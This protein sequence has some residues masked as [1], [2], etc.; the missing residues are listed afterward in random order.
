MILFPMSC[1]VL[2]PGHIKC[3]EY[4]SRI[5]QVVVSLLTAKAMKGYKEEFTPYK[6]REKIL[7]SLYLDLIVVPQNSLNP[8]SNLKKY[9]CDSIASGDGWE[10]EELEAIEKLG[11]RKI[12]IKL[13]KKYSSTNIINNIKKY[14]SFRNTGR[15]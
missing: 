12:N 9:K 7:K 8:L 1:R 6:D 15:H 4:L 3:L 14:E 5:D 2:H 10:K 13:P 11:V